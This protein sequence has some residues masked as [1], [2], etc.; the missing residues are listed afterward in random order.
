PLKELDEDSA[1]SILRESLWEGEQELEAKELADLCGRVPLQLKLTASVLSAG[2]VQY[3]EFKSDLA[4]SKG[5]GM[6]RAILKWHDDMHLRALFRLSHF[7]SSFNAGQAF[8]M[9]HGL[10]FPEELLQELYSRRLILAK[11]DSGKLLWTLHA[12]V[13]VAILD[14]GRSA[15]WQERQSIARTLFAQCMMAELRESARAASKGNFSLATRL[16]LTQQAN[17]CAAL[18][19]AS[20]RVDVCTAVSKAL[21]REWSL[22]STGGWVSAT[23][24]VAALLLPSLEQLTQAARSAVQKAAE[25]PADEEQWKQWMSDKIAMSHEDGALRLHVNVDL[26]LLS[27]KQRVLSD[28]LSLYGSILFLNGRVFEAEGKFREELEL[29]CNVVG[30]EHKSTLTCMSHLAG[31]LNSQCKLDE[32]EKKHR[33]VLELSRRM[34]GE[35]HADTL[36]SMSYLASAL[37]SQG[38]SAEAELKHREV[39]QLRREEL[40]DE[41]P[42]TLA[43]MYNLARALSTMDRQTEAE[44]T[45]RRNEAEKMY[46]QVL[47]LQCK[48]LSPENPSTSAS[49]YNL[50]YLLSSRGEYADAEHFFRKALQSMRDVHGPE[51]SSSLRTMS[52]L[53][54][55]LGNQGKWVEVEE[56]HRE[57]LELLGKVQEPLPWKTLNSIYGLAHAL[58]NQSKW[59]EVEWAYREVFGLL[60]KRLGM[61]VSKKGPVVEVHD[62]LASMVSFAHAQEGLFE[63]DGVVTVYRKLS[64]LMGEV[65]GLEQSDPFPAMYGLANALLMQHKLEEAGMVFKVLALLGKSLWPDHLALLHTIHGLLCAL[66]R[67]GKWEDVEWVYSDSVWE[68]LQLLSSLA[69]EQQ[70]TQVSESLGKWD[71]VER[72]YMEMLK[73]SQTALGP[74][75][76]TTKI[77]N[78]MIRDALQEAVAEF[79][80]E[81][82]K[83]KRMLGPEHPSTSECEWSLFIAEEKL[84]EFIDGVSSGSSEGSE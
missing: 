19:P 53:A 15:A 27:Q 69:I 41:H 61:L 47:D 22:F 66:E 48:I 34:L 35:R 43:S 7:T 29:R 44:K 38:K 1:F 5:S 67:Q 62:M 45:D 17:I 40:G 14:I 16:A 65:M 72:V 2:R 6:E 73:V 52:G 24:R 81:L 54:E 49:M 58:E 82:A 59:E 9:L 56:V 75:H 63:F 60:N 79:T 28:L 13:K 23:G 4:Q 20:E 3:E 36:A 74:T 71:E 78:S 39:L 68:M 70:S 51:H 37:D 76:P 10:D 46:R 64:E 77:I 31:A 50:A 42:D 80:Q 57:R 30:M 18:G 26:G 55:V 21:L 84:E 8:L 33:E 25:M 32:A 83:R 11:T 12:N